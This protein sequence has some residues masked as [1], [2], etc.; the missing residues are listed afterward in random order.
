MRMVVMPTA[1]PRAYPTERPL[2]RRAAY[3]PGSPRCVGNPCAAPGTSELIRA[4]LYSSL[5][6]GAMPAPPGV[7]AR[8]S[9]ALRAGAFGAN[10]KPLP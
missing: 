8:S 4:A 3:R 7:I 2:V 5:A 6:G 1:S 10:K 9:R